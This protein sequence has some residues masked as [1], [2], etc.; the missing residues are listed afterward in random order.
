MT[1][2]YGHLDGMDDTQLAG[3][4][5]MKLVDKGDP[6]RK[7]TDIVLQDQGN[8]LW[9]YMNEGRIYGVP[10][11]QEHRGLKL[12]TDEMVAN[13][14]ELVRRPR[15]MVLLINTE[16][17]EDQR[18]YEELLDA[19]ADGRAEIVDELKQFDPAKSAFLTWVRYNEL[20]FRLHPRYSYLLEE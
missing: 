18:K 12:D 17:A 1:D 10:V 6:G 14:F 8:L 2:N 7:D 4:E 20:V 5:A 11:A 16:A 13:A 19:V 15:S 3:L 9:S